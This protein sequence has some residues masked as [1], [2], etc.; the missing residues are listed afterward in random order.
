[1]CDT[2][3]GTMAG[4]ARGQA[5]EYA[6][7]VQAGRLA[8][9]E[10]PGVSKH[11]HHVIHELVVLDRLPPRFLVWNPIVIELQR[12]EVKW[13]HI[14]AAPFGIRS[15]RPRG[16]VADR[17]CERHPN[18]RAKAGGVAQEVWGRRE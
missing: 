1:M 11:A 15:L 4:L 17:M 10:Q 2:A 16:H 6:G 3:Q 14:F 18:H 9:A 5:S 12:C 13:L 8:G 7:L